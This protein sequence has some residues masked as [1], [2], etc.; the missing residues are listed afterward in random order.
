MCC[1]LNE[2]LHTTLHY[3]GDLA[4]TGAAFNCNGSLLAV[5]IGLTVNIYSVKAILEDGDIRPFNMW[6]TH[7]SARVKQV[8][9]ALLCSYAQCQDAHTSSFCVSELAPKSANHSAQHRQCTK[10]QLVQL[11]AKQTW[12]TIHEKANTWHHVSC[13]VRNI[14]Y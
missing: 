14:W 6:Y 13:K 3:D 5:A 11:K 8:T 2:I 12:C 1:S 4:V 9:Q 10:T 7:D